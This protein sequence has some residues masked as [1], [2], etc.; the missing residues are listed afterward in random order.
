M[1]FFFLWLIVV[2]LVMILM[3]YLRVRV[4]DPLFLLV[5]LNFGLQFL[6]FPV[7]HYFTLSYDERV[8]YL[9]RA[10][11][12]FY[13]IIVAFLFWS[14]GLIC[15]GRGK[16][17]VIRV[18]VGF[19]QRRFRFGFWLFGIGL[20]LYS[21]LWPYVGLGWWAAYS[22][23]LGSRLAIINTTGAFHLRNL[24]LW[25]LWGGFFVAYY[26]LCAEAKA[27]LLP[28]FVIV[29]CLILFLSLPF[30]Q[31]YQVVFPIVAGLCALYY[32]RLLPR[33]AFIL[34]G[35]PVVVLLPLLGVYREISY[36]GVFSFGELFETLFD[37][38]KTLPGF[39]ST[40]LIRFDNF[41]YFLAF[42]EAKDAYEMSLL[43]SIFNFVQLF[44][45]SGVIGFDKPLDVD[46]YLTEK[47]LGGTELGTYAFTPLAE[48]YMNLGYAGLVIMPFL[49]GVL[50]R[51]VLS[52]SYC[53]G[54][55]VFTILLFSDLFFL[56]NM[57]FSINSM[58]NVS[59]LLFLVFCLV[60]SFFYR[61][62][63]G[64]LNSDER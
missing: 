59:C 47:I 60:V 32:D 34:F 58:G 26:S 33:G 10:S 54:H 13:W 12:A 17:S 52:A 20:V 23:P 57:F 28:Y 21:A 1:E 14:L 3:A 9:D 4:L 39:L 64:L 8:V 7:S 11:G 63:P 25:F 40:F 48:W 51:I 27:R 50:C 30:G 22:D 56:K 43:S 36:Q 24:S 5:S 44:I 53:P 45:P 16:R 49:S 19:S 46:S 42:W 37:N 55:S 62:G 61:F 41:N 15:A 35:I 38:L 6:V 18:S 29:M 2:G 31:R